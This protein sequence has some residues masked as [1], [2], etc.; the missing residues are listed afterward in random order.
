MKQKTIAPVVEV[1][2]PIFDD[3][4]PDNSAPVSCDQAG[5]VLSRY[6]DL[7]WDWTPYSSVKRSSILNFAYVADDV[8]SP[9]KES[10]VAEMHWLMHLAARIR[11]GAPLSYQSLL[12]YLKVL[13]Y[14]ARYCDKRSIAI[15]GVLSSESQLLSFV[16][17]T[18]NRNA[19]DLA[20]LLSILARIG[21]SIV[22]Y[23]VVGSAAR[24]KLRALAI[25]HTNSL[26]QFPPIPTRIYSSILGVLIAELSA[27]ELV[28]DQY[29]EI[30][31]ECRSSPL[32]GRNKQ[33]QWLVAKEQHLR[34]DGVFESFRD[35]LLKHG[36]SAYA[37][38]IGL[39]PG[40]RGLSQGLYRAQLVARIAIHAFTGMRS[41][42][43]SALPFAC[44]EEVTAN[45]PTHFIISGTTTKLNHGKAKRAQ[46]VTSREGARAV[47]LA[48]RIAK[49]IF[50]T[51][52]ARTG[53]NIDKIDHQ[54]LF[55]S[56]VYLGFAGKAPTRGADFLPAKLDLGKCASLRKKIQPPIEESDLREL[57]QIDPHRAWRSEDRYRVGTPWVLTSHQMRRTLAL[58]AQRSGLVSL[59]SLRRQ[60]QHITEEMA[61][62]YARGSAFAKNFIGD[63]KQH[64]G[65]EWQEMQPVSAAYSYIF[66]VLISDDVLFGG[67]AAWIDHRLRNECGT[68][69]VDRAATMRRFKRG[70]LAYRET[71]LG[72]CTNIDSCQQIAIK[73]LDVDCLSGC[74]NLVGRLS[75]LER[76]IAA[77]TRFVATLD[78]TSIEFRSEKSDL[79]ALVSVRD[80]VREQAK[81][82]V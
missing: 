11:R 61:R 80:R 54:P 26:R 38:D 27:I 2:Y 73:W 57:E 51:A 37:A 62:Y 36:L 48:Q 20:S 72:G 9:A 19:K 35:L 65:F 42:E 1:G 46:W 78:P 23:A 24:K 10:L 12:H 64:F 22:G 67:H 25:S 33:R 58:Y 39:V 60:L 74:R 4:V 30:I 49:L 79:G 81:E 13:R 41:E 47:R 14:L 66:N 44:L 55:V 16:R 29:A 6:G 28:F 15:Q 17:D 82:K 77:Q 31:D 59:P 45:G 56:P 71:S 32:I 18:S 69:I 40:V 8:S 43:V 52:I 53:A 21:T 68:V 76:V 75:S 5:N 63:D 3:G 50:S 70:E 7:L 34:R